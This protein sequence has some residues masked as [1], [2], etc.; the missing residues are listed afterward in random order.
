MAWSFVGGCKDS[1][2]FELDLSSLSEASRKKKPGKW[3]WVGLGKFMFG[4]H[5]EKERKRE[6]SWG[7]LEGEMNHEGLWTLR[8]KLRV[9][10]GG[11]LGEPGGGY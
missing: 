6:G 4:A 8:N 1:W 7:K 10:V 11:W 2:H 5:C 3:V 9:F